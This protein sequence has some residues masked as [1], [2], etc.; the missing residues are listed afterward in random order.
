M[1]V[2]HH[3]AVTGQRQRPV[4]DLRICL[5][6]SRRKLQIPPP[7][8]LAEGGKAAR[9]GES[10]CPTMA[11]I[12]VA[13]WEGKDPGLRHPFRITTPGAVRMAGRG[14]SLKTVADNG[15]GGR[16]CQWAL[17]TLLGVNAMHPPFVTFH[18]RVYVSRA[19]ADRASAD[20]ARAAWGDLT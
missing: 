5:H 13:Q 6:Y 1:A 14:P 3:F 12:P 8:L 4:G 2:P 19:L 17:C 7:D 10:G 20:S 9:A 15:L 11:A 16:V 18:P